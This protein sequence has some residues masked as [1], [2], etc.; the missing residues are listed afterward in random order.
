MK[1]LTR[2]EHAAMWLFHERYAA[3]RDGAREFYA[4]LSA[5]EKRIVQQMLDE[6][7]PQKK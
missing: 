3:Q 6:L 1:T 2:Q 7:C 5:S 4:A